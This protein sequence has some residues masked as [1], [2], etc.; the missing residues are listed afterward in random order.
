MMASRQSGRG[1]EPRCGPVVVGVDGSDA[2]LVAVRWAATEAAGRHTPLRIV[3]AIGVPDFFPGGAV[4]P[5]TEL[6]HLLEQDAEAVLRTAEETARDVA[7]HLDVTTLSTTDAPVVA[8]IGESSSARLIVLG[9]SGRGAFAGL[10]LG[11]TTVT[12]AAHAHCP[13]VAVRGSGKPPEGAGPVVVGVDGSELSDAALGWAFAHAAFHDVPLVAVHSWSDGDP[14]EVFSAA[15]MAFDWE[16]LEDTEQRVL[17][18]R[19]AGWSARYPD[20]VVRRDVVRA[21]PRERLLEWSARAS[22]VVVGSRG[23]GGFRGLLLGSTSQ[24]LLHHAECPVMVVR[25]DTPAAGASEN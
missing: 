7:P 20:V 6:F 25:P 21:K 3:H 15:R 2:S 19:L 13:V 17:A 11:S 1:G 23:R 18:E 5:S 12:L 10:L 4:S 9:K 8:M 24:A 14:E 22:I 16:P